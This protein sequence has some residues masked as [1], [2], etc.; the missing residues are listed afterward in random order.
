[1]A[2]LGVA[3][4]LRAEALPKLAAV[5]VGLPDGGGD[6]SVGRTRN[7]AWAPVAVELEA[8]EPVADNRYRLRFRST[9]S[10]DMAYTYTV[11]VPG[12]AR[13]E[14]RT[15]LGYLRPGNLS[16]DFHVTLQ[17]ADGAEVPGAP[18]VTVPRSGGQEVLAPRDYLIVVLGARPP[19]LKRTL[20]PVK[21]DKEQPVDDPEEPVRNLAFLESVERLPDRW[22]G[23]E[24]AD[25]I[26]LPTGSDK[27]VT[28]LLEDQS[29][30]RE[31]LAEWV[32]RG[33]RLVIS[34]GRNHQAAAKLLEKMALLRCGVEGTKPRSSLDGL[35]AWFAPQTP[36]LRRVEI[37]VLKPG[38]GTQVLASEAP[39]TEAGG[40]R[41]ERPVVV[42]AACGV[43]QVLLVAFDLDTGPFTESP[44]SAS[45]RPFWIKLLEQMGI[46]TPEAAPAGPP[47]PADERPENAELADT[48]QAGL[49]EFAEV[50]TVPFGLVALFILVYIILVGPLDYFIIKKVFKRLEWTWVTFPVLVIA[51]SALAY[52]TAYSIKGEDLRVNEVDLVEIDLRTQQVYGTTWA[53]LF[54]PRIQNYS[55][56]VGPAPEW[57]KAPPSPTAM[58]TVLESPARASRLG[59][60]ALFRR[61]YSYAEDAHG[62]EKVPVPVWATRSFTASWRAPFNPDQPPVAASLRVLGEKPSGTVTNNLPVRLADA[63]LFYKG[64]AYPLKDVLPAGDPYLYPGQ[65]VRLDQLFSPAVRPLDLKD[66]LDADP[67]A[68]DGSTRSA[69]PLMKALLF[70][71]AAGKERGPNSGLRRLDQSWRLREPPRPRLGVEAPERDEVIL[72]AR[73]GPRAGTADKLTAESFAPARLKM[74]PALTGYLTQETFVR[75]YIPLDRAK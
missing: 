2:L 25:L 22:F 16:S 30:R 27:F 29:G 23:Y 24:A 38:P 41:Q 17:A 59:S 50:P 67:A 52:F 70:H 61:P 65:E 73:A 3:L 10:E 14:R 51:V 15:V 33:G 72:V 21:G 60:Q 49:E 43:G 28:D 68:G 71:E 12:L 1:L 8:D 36:R 46:H 18:T 40:D 54:S 75:V 53:T 74:E 44:F 32:R 66:W 63:T 55:L 42:Q 64:K 11:P 4:P 57:A 35:A 45:R 48:F 39:G 5:R 19:G 13:G 6:K 34:V 47:A 69:A 56:T 58:V 9:D 26:I 62:M 7:G 20:T 31:A 37:A